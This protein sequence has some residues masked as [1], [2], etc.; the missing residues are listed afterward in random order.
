MASPL[1]TLIGFL[2]ESNI[3]CMPTQDLQ[4]TVDN[5]YSILTDEVLHITLKRFHLLLITYFM[6]IVIGFT[7]TN[8]ESYSGKRFQATKRF[9][10]C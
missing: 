3:E 4:S 7:I 6:T 1:N 8:S 5:N 2:R 10:G 9:T